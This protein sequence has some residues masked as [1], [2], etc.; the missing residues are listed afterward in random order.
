MKLFIVT[1]G[2]RLLLTWIVFCL[3]IPGSTGGFARSFY[4]PPEVEP[5]SLAKIVVRIKPVVK[6]ADAS[7][8][9][10]VWW[11]ELRHDSR[12]QLYRTPGGPV[13]TGTP[14]TLRLRAASGDLTAA[15]VRIFNDRQ[16][17]L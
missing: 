16:N 15:Q 7:H 1:L 11:N 8:D 10:E 12:D 13:A 4:S 5:L 14:V 9:N 2:R 3:L 6:K 17:T